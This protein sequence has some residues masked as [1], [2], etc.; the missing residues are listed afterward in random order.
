MF[1]LT[2]Y[3][4]REMLLLVYTIDVRIGDAVILTILKNY[5]T[6][7]TIS[8]TKKKKFASMG[9]S[10]K[11]LDR[12]KV[13]TANNVIQNIWINI[14]GYRQMK[15]QELTSR[16]SDVIVNL[17][18][19]DDFTNYRHHESILG[20]AGDCAAV[21]R[22]FNQLVRELRSIIEKDPTKLPAIP[23]TVKVEYEN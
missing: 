18:V 16:M 14:E 10:L 2:Y 17:Q 23:E 21:V 19:F 4:T 20:I 22:E 8:Y 7:I 5:P 1:S 13:K 11:K 3:T 12:L 15:E 6:K 9:T